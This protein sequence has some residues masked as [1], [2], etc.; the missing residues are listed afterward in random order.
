MPDSKLIEKKLEQ[1]MGEISSD[2]VQV[3]RYAGTA[4]CTGKR[5]EEDDSKFWLGQY[6]ALKR[7][8]DN[9]EKHMF[10]LM[11]EREDKEKCQKI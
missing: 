10:T 1:I 8:Y 11:I 9:V 3:E 5:D 6:K 4:F 2:M 7:I